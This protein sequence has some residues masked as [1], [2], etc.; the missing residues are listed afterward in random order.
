MLK[1]VSATPLRASGTP[2]SSGAPADPSETLTPEEHPA[3]LART[4]G[5]VGAARQR[6]ASPRV[7]SN[8]AQP[9]GVL[10]WERDFL[11]ELAVDALE[12]FVGNANEEPGEFDEEHQ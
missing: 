8:L 4:K 10:S 9:A 12:D 1:T 7:A 2:C 11:L 5:S 3:Q 6:G